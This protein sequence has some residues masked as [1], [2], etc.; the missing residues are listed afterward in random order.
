MEQTLSQQLLH[1]INQHY[2]DF[3]EQT[4]SHQLL[5]LINQTLKRLYGTNIITTVT[6]SD[7]SNI[8]TTLWNKHYHNSYYI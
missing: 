7:K 1:L 4:L 8:K 5:H 2:N 3:M 6:T